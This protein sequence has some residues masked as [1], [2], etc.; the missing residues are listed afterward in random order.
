MMM[1]CCD[2]FQGGG[3]I[4]AKLIPFV[5]AAAHAC[6]GLVSRKRCDF[7]STE[8]LQFSPC[9]HFSCCFCSYL[10]LCAHAIRSIMCMHHEAL[11]LSYGQ[12]IWVGTSSYIAALKE[13]LVVHP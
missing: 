3:G 6:S 8:T 9:S 11:V 7:E 5:F 4:Q 13:R 10:R 1:P 12:V 2:H